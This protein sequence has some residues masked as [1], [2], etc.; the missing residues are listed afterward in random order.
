MLTPVAPFAG[1]ADVG[2]P[3]GG[4]GAA[5]VVNDHTGPFVVPPALRATI[6]QKYCLLVSNVP[7]AYEA[8]GWPVVT[9]G[10]GFTVPNL[11][12]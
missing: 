10:G 3:G 5:L 9:C 6:C 4:G 12:S 8:D 1:D 2:V 11:T 7:G